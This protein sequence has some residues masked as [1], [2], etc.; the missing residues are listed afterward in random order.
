MQTGRHVIFLGAGAS[1]GSGYPLANGLRLLISSRKQWEAALRQYQK[2]HSLDQDLV[3]TG[4][5]Y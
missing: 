5:K 1:K 2:D 4:L 3:T